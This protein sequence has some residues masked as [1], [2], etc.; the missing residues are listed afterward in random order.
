VKDLRITNNM[1]SHNLLRNLEAAQGRMD[2]LQNRMSSGKR[3]SRPSDDPVGI[4][5]ALRMKSSIT[6]VEQWKANASE[7]LAY[8]NTADSTMGDI[9]AMLQR[10]RE[11]AIQGANGSNSD[12]DKAKIAQEVDQITEQIKQLANTKVGSKYLFGGTANVKPYDTSTDTWVGSNDVVEF[13]VGSSL[14]LAI[15]VNGQTLFGVSGGSVGMVTTLQNLSASLKNPSLNA[16]IETAMGELDD[17]LNMVLN[18]RAELGARVN[19][20]NSLYEQLDSTLLNLQASLSEIMDAD[21]AETI[22]EFKNQENVYRAALSVGAQ[23]I[24]P[25]LV[26]FM[27]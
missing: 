10:A 26:D 2:Q 22:V 6:A 27:K 5:N 3:I 4:E 9:S 23:I 13:Q 16:G 11:L 19:R 25:S 7:G 20:M 17:Q 8:M 21:M 24:Q 12:D 1:L 18:K 15:S 14:S